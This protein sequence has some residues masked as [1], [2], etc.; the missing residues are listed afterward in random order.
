MF[1]GIIFDYGGVLD[2]GKGFMHFCE[3]YAEKFNKTPEELNTIIKKYWRLAR[4]EKIPSSEF[5][6]GISRE[7][8]CD[9]DYFESL[10][11]G[12]P[13]VDQ[14]AMD[15]VKSL[16]NNY[17]LA[18]LSNHIRDWLE[19]IVKDNK[20]D[21]IFDVIMASY[22]FGLEKPNIPIYEEVVEKLELEPEEC[23]FIDDQE[24]NIPPARE[25]GMKAI[26]FRDLSQLK[27]ELEK[28]DLKF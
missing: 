4:T 24:N 18:L 6:E 19:E 14:E 9:R 10:M 26:L 7:L 13:V 23:V 20:L 11:K 3:R 8:S 2:T 17:K 5:W 16:K 21:Q 25:I 15:L 12:F 28:L 1:K 22:E 27:K